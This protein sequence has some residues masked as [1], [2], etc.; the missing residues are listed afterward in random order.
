MGIIRFAIENPVKVTVAVILIVLFGL[1]SLFEIPIQLTPDVDRP[2]IT[3]QTFWAGASPQEIES[4]IVDRQEEKLKSVTNL[5]KMTSTSRES[6]AS[7]KLEFPVGVDKDIAYRDVS[8]KLRQVSNYP[9]EVDEPVMS[10]TD[11]EMANT[12]AWMILYAEEG[13]DIAHL[14]TF[15]EDQ[16]KPQ[17]ERAEGVAEVSVYGGLDREIQVEVDAHLLAARGLTFRN[18]EAALRRQNINISAGTIAQGKRDYTYRTVGEYRNTEDIENTVIAY[19]D[20]GPILVRDVAK[21][22]DGLKKQYAFVRSKGKYVLALPAR[23]ETGANVIDTM[24]NLKTQLASVNREILHPRGLGLELTQVYDETTYIWSAIWLVVRNIFFG[25]LLA[26]IVLLLFLRSGSATGIIAVAIPISVIGTFLVITLLG[27][28]LNVVM[29]AGMAFAVGMVVDNAIVVLENIY[30]HRAMGKSRGQAALDGAREVWGAVLASTLTTMAVFLPVITIQEEAGQLFKDI[31]IAIATAVGLSLTVSILVIPPLASRF[32]HASKAHALGDKPWRFAQWVSSLV[33][34]INRRIGTRLAVVAGLSGLAFLGSWWLMPAAEYLPAGNQNL[35]FG[36]IFSPPGYSI[37]EFKRMGLIVE[38]GDP[39]DPYDGIRRAWEASEDEELAARLP[40]V[41]IPVGK[42]GD[43]VQ[44]VVPPPIDNFFYVAFS[45]SAFMGCTSKESTNVK[46]LEYVMADAGDRIPGVFTMFTQTS[47]FR[48]GLRGGGSVDMEIRADDLD[49]VVASANAIMGMV[50]ANGY[51]YPSPD[52]ANFALGRPEIQLIPDRAR[53]ADVGLDVRDLGFI[54]EACIDGAF[55]GEYNDRGDKIDMVITVAGTGGAT[56]EEIGQI[57]IFTATGHGVPITSVAEL[58]RTTAP[59]QIN[60]IE[61]MA[62]VTLSIKPKTG[63][64]LAETMRELEED[65]IAPLR[66]SGAIPPSVTTALAGTADKLTQTQRALVGNFEGVVEQP[67]L[68]GLS[69]SSSMGILLLAVLIIA[70]V[71]GLTLGA[72]IAT[73][74]TVGGLV[75]LCVVFLALNPALVLT[76]VQSRAI[77]ALLITYLLMAALFE[78]F[79]YPFAIMF[80]V[81]LAAVGGFAALRIVHEVSLYDVTSPIQQLDV[82]TM[83]GFVILIGI[84][85]NNAILIV[86]QALNFQ[87]EEGMEPAAAVVRSVQTRTRPIFMS[88]MTSI[89]GMAPLVIMPGAGS[90]LYRGLGSVVLGGL[91]VSTIFTLVVVPAIFTLLMDFQ[92]WLGA[93]LRV[94][95]EGALEPVVAPADAPEA[96]GPSPSAARSPNS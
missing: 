42:K 91:L 44:T 95:S 64:P 61:E 29:L 66:A 3:V 30:R 38:E 35:V 62:S 54:V 65:I 31:A 93:T 89:F 57:P 52:P 63:V 4:E 41:D 86:H 51:G 46:P 70:A 48:G 33:G 36:F 96:V 67:R 53:A 47:L 50:M 34:A 11:A 78:S 9:E 72:R 68:L 27:R 88:A 85:V 13:Q 90:E 17:L 82:L 37:D 77:L 94:E 20:G 92:R 22:I 10:A 71:A 21:V 43:T 8:D 32:F 12:I 2:V 81:P 24:R 26:V 23:R 60:H 40:T 1:L 59:Q 15:V 56:V 87:R 83:L 7:I 76:L 74:A 84:V 5:K 16:V 79:A 18:V 69:V 28:T 45:G 58:R 19:R 25:G 73:I 80:T 14:K 55:V 6:E 75:L 49:A 39:N